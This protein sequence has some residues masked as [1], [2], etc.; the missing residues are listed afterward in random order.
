M[1]VSKQK[2]LVNKIDRQ[3]TVLGQYLVHHEKVPH[4]GGGWSK[5]HRGHLVDTQHIEATLLDDDSFRKPDMRPIS[6]HEIQ[7]KSDAYREISLTTDVLRGAL[8]QQPNPAPSEIFN[9]LGAIQGNLIM[10]EKGIDPL[11]IAYLPELPEKI[12]EIADEKHYEELSTIAGNVCEASFLIERLSYMPELTSK[13]SDEITR[14]ADLTTALI[15]N[16]FGYKELPVTA[17]EAKTIMETIRDELPAVIEKNDKETSKTFSEKIKNMVRN[18]DVV[19]AHNETYTSMRDAFNRVTEIGGFLNLLQEQIES[20][21]IKNR[22]KAFHNLADSENTLAFVQNCLGSVKAFYPE[23]KALNEDPDFPE[24]DHIEVIQKQFELLEMTYVDYNARSEI[25]PSY[26]NDFN[27]PRIWTGY[28][29]L[30]SEPLEKI[31]ERLDNLAHINELGGELDNQ[32]LEKLSGFIAELTYH[33]E[34][35]FPE[36]DFLSDIPE[37]A[38]V[39]RPKDFVLH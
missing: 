38:K 10:A 12:R 15:S 31:M 20:L 19:I 26:K 29:E 33:C 18:P 8:A 28:N 34:T 6:G 11:Y 16:R 1:G 39:K 37:G 36:V 27:T 32:G 4:E 3:L 35:F 25:N 22:Q 30:I 13:D 23:G 17:S 21:A 9:Y 2:S 24:P 7:G 5:Y 14:I